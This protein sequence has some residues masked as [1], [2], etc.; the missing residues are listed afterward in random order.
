[1]MPNA[2][3]DVNR[4]LPQPP[5]CQRPRRGRR[6]RA[7]WAEAT[8][9]ARAHAPNARVSSWWRYRPLGERLGVQPCA[10]LRQRSQ[11][12]SPEELAAIRSLALTKSLRPLAA[13]FGV[14]HETVRAVIQREEH[15][16]EYRSRRHAP[17]PTRGIGDRGTQTG[18]PSRATRLGPST[19]PAGG[20]PGLRKQDVGTSASQMTTRR[21]RRARPAGVVLVR[22]ALVVAGPVRTVRS[23]SSRSLLAAGEDA[24]HGDRAGRPVEG[25]GDG[26]V[27]PNAHRGGREPP[28]A[29]PS[30]TVN[31]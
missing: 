30:G 31:I 20:C 13:E 5:K 12:L 2:R 22:Q 28:T 7:A 16:D 25:G 11:R 29:K 10:V 19:R 17:E 4:L 24:R 8:G 23:P 26:Q 15:H 6:G 9:V 27:L 14:S 18:R 3:R 21:R 1:M